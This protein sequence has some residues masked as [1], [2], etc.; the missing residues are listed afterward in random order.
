MQRSNGRRKESINH[1]L[2]NHQAPLSHRFFADLFR[3]DAHGVL[4][5]EHENLAVADLAGL[6]RATTTVTALSTMSSASTT[7]TFTFG[8]KSTVYSLPR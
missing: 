1:Q 7:S 3:A 8:R 4:D 2:V 6:G 5:R